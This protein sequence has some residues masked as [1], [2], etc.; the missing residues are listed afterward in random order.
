MRKSIE[1]IRKVYSEY[2]ESMKRARTPAS[3]SP[4]SACLAD[5]WGS[6]YEDLWR[7]GEKSA[8]SL[9]GTTISRK[10][11][12]EPMDKILKSSKS[13]SKTHFFWMSYGDLIVNL[14]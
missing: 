14:L 13:I 11:Y 5:S 3:E 10:F 8:K 9:I 12:G 4:I 2:M 1:S 6:F 7:A